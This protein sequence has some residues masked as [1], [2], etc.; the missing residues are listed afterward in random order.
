M[1]LGQQGGKEGGEE[2]EDG[3][4]HS[5]LLLLLAQQGAGGGLQEDV[6]QVLLQGEGDH[7][8][9]GLGQDW[10]KWMHHHRLKQISMNK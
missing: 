4:R 2:G 10:N 6:L 3:G 1:S 9:G 5:H 8:P 7:L